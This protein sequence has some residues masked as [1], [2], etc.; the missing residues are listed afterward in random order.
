MFNRHQCY[1]FIINHEGGD[2]FVHHRSIQVDGFRTL[3]NERREG[4]DI[5]PGATGPVAIDIKAI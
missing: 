3:S 5:K 2:V 4:F 1:R